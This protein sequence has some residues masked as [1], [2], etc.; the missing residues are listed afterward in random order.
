MVILD[1]ILFVLYVC[2]VF[3]SLV[4]FCIVFYCWVAPSAGI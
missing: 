3:S 1:V 2:I 4:T